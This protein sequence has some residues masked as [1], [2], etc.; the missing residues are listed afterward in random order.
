MFPV[1][2]LPC[3]GSSAGLSAVPV[4]V[5][6]AVWFS[7]GILLRSDALRRALFGLLVLARS[8]VVPLVV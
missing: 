7:V 2:A 4:M 3:V 1:L 5:W 6:R 8:D